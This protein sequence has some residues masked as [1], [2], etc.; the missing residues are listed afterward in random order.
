MSLAFNNSAKA[1]KHN[2]ELKL[3]EKDCEYFAHQSAALY[4]L[5]IT[6]LAPWDQEDS[7]RNT[8]IGRRLLK[9]HKKATHKLATSP[10]ALMQDHLGM[11]P[12]VNLTQQSRKGRSTTEG[13]NF[14]QERD[15]HLTFNDIVKYHQGSG[16]L[17]EDLEIL[18]RKPRQVI[19]AGLAG[20]GLVAAGSWI[21]HSLHL[22]ILFDLNGNDGK[23]ETL[24]IDL[25]RVERHLKMEDK[26]LNDLS[27]AASIMLNIETHIQTEIYFSHYLGVLR[28]HFETTRLQILTL[29]SG[30]GDLLHHR[31]TPDLI[32][33][34]KLKQGFEA[35]KLEAQMENLI[36]LLDEAGGLYTLPASHFYSK[37]NFTFFIAIG[38]PLGNKHS[39]MTLYHYLP[40]PTRFNNTNK[41]DYLMAIPEVEFLGV[42][43]LNKNYYELS[44]GDL[45][46]CNKINDRYVCPPTGIQLGGEESCLVNLFEGN[47]AKILKTCEHKMVKRNFLIQKDIHTF[48]A[49]LH[50]SNMLKLDCEFMP[51]TV[52]KRLQGIVS[53]HLP[54]G[55]TA[56]VQNYKF[57]SKRPVFGKSI[58]LKVSDLPYTDELG[59]EFLE[60]IATLETK[61]NA[62]LQEDSEDLDG[63]SLYIDKKTFG[64]H[65]LGAGIVA[66]IILG[67][68]LC[69]SLGC[70]L[71][72]RTAR[73]RLKKRLRNNSENRNNTIN[74]NT[75]PNEPGIEMR[76]QLL[77]GQ[78]SN[79]TAP[80]PGANPY[81]V[82]PQAQGAGQLAATRNSNSNYYSGLPNLNK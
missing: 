49:Y 38:V 70:V 24:Q 34:S 33:F 42:S 36:P 56:S 47:S 57:S 62:T 1:A 58:D 78:D 54:F 12:V 14:D 25:G 69:V 21:F 30:L 10:K 45:Q 75:N 2:G 37:S 65:A 9:S 22:D 51:N 19:V 80:P 20:A 26:M 72:Y 4:Q 52:S 8:K 39:E 67:T 43:E 29:V 31:I 46:L 6:S 35:L 44:A 68:L 81:P 73:R 32:N 64:G 23:I 16:T 13:L 74:I 71:W 66:S 53:I 50:K 7:F 11:Y 5:L 60:K 3:Y 79:A 61:V 55:C 82:L 77:H 40:F 48:Q 63:F 41:Y 17:T 28:A 59:P 18:A 27:N 15:I 76:E